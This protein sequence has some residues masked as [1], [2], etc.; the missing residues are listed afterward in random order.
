MVCGLTDRVSR[1]GV[2]GAGRGYVH[3]PS[4]TGDPPG[5]QQCAQARV[6]V[7]AG[8]AAASSRGGDAFGVLA[9]HRD[10]A[11]REAVGPVVLRRRACLGEHPPHQGCHHPPC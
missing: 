7:A 10:H 3:T 9:D 4:Q 5:G 6:H 2:V 11:A 1:R 8:N